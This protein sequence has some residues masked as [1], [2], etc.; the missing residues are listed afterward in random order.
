MWIRKCRIKHLVYSFFT[1]S[2]IYFGF[3]KPIVLQSVFQETVDNVKCKSVWDFMADFSNN[4]ILNPELKYFDI[5]DESH[6][7]NGEWIYGVHYT[8]F[9]EHLPSF[10]EN[11]AI[12]R[13][14]I[15]YYI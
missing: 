8:E 7:A 10:M 5:L 11:S 1:L 3:W 6:G 9:F 4:K 14:Y 15:S 13:Y 2:V 12:G